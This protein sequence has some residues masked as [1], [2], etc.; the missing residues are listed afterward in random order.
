MLWRKCNIVFFREKKILSSV[1][2]VLCG[3]QLNK[4]REPVE[5]EI[6]HQNMQQQIVFDDAYDFIHPPKNKREQQTRHKK[7]EKNGKTNG[8]WEI[9]ISN[10]SD[11]TTTDF[12]PA[13]I[14]NSAKVMGL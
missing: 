5:I 10:E 2:L 4:Q 9:T 3:A 12:H 1:G 14:W 8:H 11:K 7:R 13:Q 6:R